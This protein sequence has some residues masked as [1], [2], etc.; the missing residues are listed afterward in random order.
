MATLEIVGTTIDGGDGD[1]LLIGSYTSH[2][3]DPAGLRAIHREWVRADVTY[4]TRL[5]Y[6]RGTP[7]GGL[8]GAFLLD[9]WLMYGDVA[10]DSISGR[11]GRDSFFPAWASYEGAADRRDDR[12]RV[13]DLGEDT[14]D[15]LMTS[16]DGYG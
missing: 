3:S 7:S 9:V 13:L 2:D 15:V 1:D 8:N 16:R 5:A 4:A 12:P 10:A 11:A 6:L 14:Y